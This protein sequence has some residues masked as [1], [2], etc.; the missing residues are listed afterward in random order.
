M[1]LVENDLGRYSIG[2]AADGLASNPDGSLTLYLQHD[3]P[4]DN[5]PAANRLPAP[6]APFKLAM[7]FSG[8]S[9]AVL[10]ASYHLPAVT[11]TV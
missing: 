4:G 5:D 10:D 3:R 2:S 1:S 9:T 7:R 11:K 6:H 8:P